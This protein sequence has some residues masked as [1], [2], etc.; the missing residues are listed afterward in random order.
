MSSFYQKYDEFIQSS[1]VK[2]LNEGFS[3]RILSKIKP[4]DD[5][6]LR[7]NIITDFIK[8]KKENQQVG[9]NIN[10]IF[11]GNVSF[12]EIKH[13]NLPLLAETP[14]MTELQNK[15]DIANKLEDE[16]NTI[17]VKLIQTC[18]KLNSTQNSIK[19]KLQKEGA[20]F[21]AFCD[22]NKGIK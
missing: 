17:D 3:N 16:L 7:E 1:F 4:I 15:Q 19:I 9:I 2:T 10:K 11:G 5:V 22:R 6:N 8:L 20:R 21:A 12:D 18:E 14:F 13:N